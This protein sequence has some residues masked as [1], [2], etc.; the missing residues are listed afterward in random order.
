MVYFIRLIDIEAEQNVAPA[1]GG[2][3]DWTSYHSTQDIHDWM[4]RL[5]R[6]YPNYLTVQ[7]IGY[8]YG[9]RPI[10]MIKLSRKT[11]IKFKIKVSIAFVL[12]IID[13]RA[14]E[15]FL[16]KLIFTLANGFPGL[17]P[18]MC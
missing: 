12:S 18:L 6:D 7:N 3:L 4:D 8:S 16:S 1:A 17:L 14:I 15:L 13:F 10:K 9:L 2:N 5:H 11:V